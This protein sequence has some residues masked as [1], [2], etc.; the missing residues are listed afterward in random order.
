MVEKVGVRPSRMDLK[1]ILTTYHLCDLGKVMAAQTSGCSAENGEANGQGPGGLRS[2]ML[3][4]LCLY[5][6]PNVLHQG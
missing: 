1:L 4:D 5:V 6:S 2:E 3:A